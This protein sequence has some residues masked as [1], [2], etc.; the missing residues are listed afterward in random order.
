MVTGWDVLGAQERGRTIGYSKTTASRIPNQA[1][2]MDLLM[3]PRVLVCDVMDI[4]QTSR[5]TVSY[6]R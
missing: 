3:I 4:T 1:V 5:H 2:D 6:N